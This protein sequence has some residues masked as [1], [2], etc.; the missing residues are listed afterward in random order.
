MIIS[1]VS[2]KGGVGKSTVTINL[3][4]A[5]AGLPHKPTVAL[6]DSDE[7][8]SCIE[9]LEGHG[10]DN[11]HL[12]EALEKPHKILEGLKEQVII[13]DTPPIGHDVAYQCAASSSLV[14]VPLQPSPLDVRSLA[15]TVRALTVIKEKYRPKLQTRFLINRLSAGTV[16]GTEIRGYLNKLYPAIPVLDSVLHDRQAYK[17][18]LLTQQSV[19]EFDKS[20]HAAKEMG[21]LVIEIV[22]IAKIKA[23]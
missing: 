11:L 5:I 16:L 17:Q 7:Q 19:I 22:N 3:A 2:Q 8:R 15:K 20:S 13:C 21:N 6:V 4:L 23:K 1:I 18:S 9:T 14:I 10:R 12:Y